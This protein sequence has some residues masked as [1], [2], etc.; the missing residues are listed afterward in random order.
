M[1]KTDKK[2]IFLAKKGME[3]L[4]NKVYLHKFSQCA[5]GS[6]V[7]IICVINGQECCC[8]QNGHLLY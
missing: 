4:K 3:M 6:T 2:R 7:F 8:R 5:S 1:E